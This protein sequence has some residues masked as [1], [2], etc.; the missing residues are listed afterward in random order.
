MELRQIK[1]PTLC[2]KEALNKARKHAYS[3]IHEGWM[4]DDKNHTSQKE[5][6]WTEQ[7]V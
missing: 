4:L 5:I 6:G 7:K 1:L 3:S 2:A